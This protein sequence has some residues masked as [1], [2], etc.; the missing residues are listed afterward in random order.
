V[1]PKARQTASITAGVV[2]SSS[3]M[4]ILVSPTGRRLIP[5]SR[6]DFRIAPWNGPT[7]TVTVSKTFLGKTSNPAARSPSAMSTVRAWTLWA[8]PFSPFGPW[9]TA[10]IDAMT[11]SRACAVQ[12]L[13]VAF[14]RRICCSR[15]WSARR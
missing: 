1:T 14:S 9:K 6:A 4:P 15:V 11:A 2:H 8:I 5:S 3:A 12:T 10:Y 13:E 7:S